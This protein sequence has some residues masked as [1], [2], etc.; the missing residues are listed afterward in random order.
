MIRVAVENISQYGRASQGVRVMR[1][2]AGS[3]VID[4]E[5][6]EREEAS[7][8]EDAELSAEEEPEA[9]PEEPTEE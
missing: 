1:P 2:V 8:T 6:T 3:R 4:I 5:K 9:F 7:E